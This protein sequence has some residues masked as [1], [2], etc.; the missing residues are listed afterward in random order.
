M[1]S[2]YDA[3]WRQGSILVADLPLDC[4]ILG[5]DGLPAR[6]QS[7]HGRWAV[8]TQDCDL[9]QTESGDV[10]PSIEL[11]SVLTVDPPTDWGLRSARLRLTDTEFVVSAGP[12]T[13]VSGALS[14]C[15]LETGS[16]RSDVSESRR[17][18]FTT[19]LGLRYDRP[20]VPDD[21]LILAKRIAHEATKRSHRPTGLIVRDVLMDLDNSTTP[22]QYSLYAVLEHPDDEQAARGWLAEVALAVPTDLGVPAQLLAATAAGISIEVLEHSY[23]A[24][25]SQLT[26]RPN[27]PN[28]EGAL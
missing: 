17:L 8:A 11:R 16:E 23:A 22:H 13:F 14:T 2:L 10:E 24:D 5:E 28:P 18:A 21:L 12:R 19:W 20:A 27:S 7:S 25:V 1:A 3:G 6:R 4:V 26:W 9:V 15:L